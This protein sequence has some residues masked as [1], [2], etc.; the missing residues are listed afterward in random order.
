LHELVWI[1]K[2]IKIFKPNVVM[3]IDLRCNLLAVASSKLS[4]HELKSMA[5]THVNLP[6]LT[7]D[8]SK[9]IAKYTLMTIIHFFYERADSLICVSRGLSRHLKKDFYIHKMI[10]TIYYGKDLKIGRQRLFTKNRVVKIVSVGRLSVQKDFE[11]LIRAVGL[12]N[13][14]YPN[15]ELWI[16]G[17]G[18]ERVAL[19]NLSREL[20]IS[21][22]IK[23]LGW[24][25]DTVN[26]FDKGDFF[27]LSSKFEGF[28][29]VLIE[30]MAR[31][32]PVISTNS[33]YGPSEILENGKYGLLVPVGNERLLKSAMRA[34]M[35]NK[36]KY[37]Y[38]SMQS[39]KRSKYFSIKNM[40]EA[41]KKTLD[42]LI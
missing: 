42:R 24:V 28:G 38:Y 17:D 29:Y 35:T 11:T 10:E 36:K 32:L 7:L 40:L 26:L 19:E 41:Y 15:F 6:S 30:A 21:N 18:L 31:G 16:A 20:N 37:E 3:G 1:K 14:E 8:I 39:I 2:Q 13:I 25:K 12:L 23:F 27:V 4:S 5:T 9:G 22:K 34:I 33:P